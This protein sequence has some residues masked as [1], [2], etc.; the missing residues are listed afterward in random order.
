MAYCG[1]GND[2]AYGVSGNDIFYGNDG[3]D[4]LFGGAG[5]NQVYGNDGNDTLSGGAGRDILGGDGG[6]DRF[7][8]NFTSESN[9]ANRDLIT[10]FDF[11]SDRIDLDGID[12]IVGAGNQ[13]FSPIAG[14]GVGQLSF[15]EGPGDH[16]LI[17]GN[18]VAGGGFELQIEV[19]DG[20]DTAGDWSTVLHFL[21]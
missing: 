15:W 20:A 13:D 2:T 21:L 19:D 14:I 4:L 12:A 18:T 1:T 8:Y 6:A 11:G 10:S 17:L 7:D 3:N 16:T 5:D 9:A